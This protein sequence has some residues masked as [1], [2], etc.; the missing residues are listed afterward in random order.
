MNSAAF[1]RMTWRD[2]LVRPPAGRKG[3]NSALST[4]PVNNSSWRPLCP[5][6][7]Q[8]WSVLPTCLLPAWVPCALTNGTWRSFWCS[9][10][11]SPVRIRRQGEVGG[12]LP[13]R[14]HWQTP[15][16]KRRPWKVEHQS[17]RFVTFFSASPFLGSSAASLLFPVSTFLVCLHIWWYCWWCA[18]L[19][20]RSRR[21]SSRQC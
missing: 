14:A 21:I 20:P 13:A 16:P 18:C 12:A 4:A 11:T 17:G 6:P 19:S 2:N 15:D 7:G 5:A 8:L 9:G 10:P 3:I 1:S